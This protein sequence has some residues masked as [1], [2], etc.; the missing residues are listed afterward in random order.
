MPAVTSAIVAVAG[1]GLS[2]GQMIHQGNKRKDAEAAGEAAVNRARGIQEENQLSALQAPTEGLELA[3]EQQARREAT[4]IPALQAD[5]RTALGG[6][7]GVAQQGAEADLELAAKTDEAIYKRDAAVMG[8]DAAID[9]RRAERD[10][11]IEEM[12][13]K[14]AGQAAADSQKAGTEAFDSAIGLGGDLAAG[15]HEKWK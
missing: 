1:I 3:K 15:I 7:I 8:E 12:E 14:G 2:I 4:L 11:G 9:K 13:I 6:T 10:M 5:A